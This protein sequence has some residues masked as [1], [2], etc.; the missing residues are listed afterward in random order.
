MEMTFKDIEGNKPLY[1]FCR[2]IWSLKIALE[3]NMRYLFLASLISADSLVNAEACEDSIKHIN[4]ILKNID[5]FDLKVELKKE[6]VKFLKDGLKIAKRDL[7]GFK[8]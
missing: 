8:N 1:E 6:V 2:K 4:F 5:L 3:S 7:S